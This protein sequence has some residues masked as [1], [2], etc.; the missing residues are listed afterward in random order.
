MTGS[1]RHI[2]AV[3]AEE[4]L[5]FFIDNSARILALPENVR[6]MYLS[7]AGTY[8]RE[9]G[10]DAQFL[11]GSHANEHGSGTYD[12]LKPQ[13][14]GAT[15]IGSTHD[16]SRKAQFSRGVYPIISIGARTD[17]LRR[18]SASKKESTQRKGIGSES[19]MRAI[20]TKP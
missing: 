10:Y 8:Y 17:S 12:L 5:Q 7:A 1:D 16:L 4:A 6:V 19:I 2:Y 18:I 3:P 20:S 14:I 11:L 13:V 15:H 9:R